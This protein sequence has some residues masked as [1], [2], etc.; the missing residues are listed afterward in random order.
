MHLLNLKGQGAPAQPSVEF[1]TELKFWPVRM[2]FARIPAVRPP[3]EIEVMTGSLRPRSAVMLRSGFR[4][5][6]THTRVQRPPQKQRISLNRKAFGLRIE[7][8]SLSVRFRSRLPKVGFLRRPAW[9][10][11]P[12]APA[13]PH[14]GAATLPAAVATPPSAVRAEP[15]RHSLGGGDTSADDDSGQGPKSK[16]KGRGKGRGKSKG[17]AGGAGA[18]KAGKVGKSTK[19]GLMPEANAL[20]DAPA[21]AVTPTT[22]DDDANGKDKS[23]TASSD[24]V[25]ANSDEVA[26]ETDDRRICYAQF[27]K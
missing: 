27:V 26:E 11:P 6:D 22:A 21:G 12:S 16:E 25:L 14:S 19:K 1:L 15:L 17:H 2:S 13:T 3:A 18:K 9:L 8:S 24:A 5:R 23:L 7:S 20:S 10:P 4:R